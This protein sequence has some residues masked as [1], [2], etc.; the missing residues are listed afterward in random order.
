MTKCAARA[1]AFLTS[2]SP[3]LLLSSQI[4]RHPRSFAVR[5][6]FP[7]LS[8]WGKRTGPR[9]NSDVWQSGYLLWRFVFRVAEASAK[10]K[11]LVMNCKGPWEGYRRQAKHVSPV[12]SFPPSFA[13]TFSSRER[14]LGTRPLFAVVFFG[15]PSQEN[16]PRGRLLTMFYSANVAQFV[17][18]VQDK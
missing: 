13:R 3:S 1:D 18:R 16:R 6:P 17:P 10:R 2:S 15:S 12:V 11:W 14:R 8:P 4:L 9:T 7:S 5:F